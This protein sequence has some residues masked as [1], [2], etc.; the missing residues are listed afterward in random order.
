MC[1]SFKA[2]FQGG[3]AFTSC[4]TVMYYCKTV[5]KKGK[6]GGIKWHGHVR[7]L[8]LSLMHVSS[9]PW[10]IPVLLSCVASRGEKSHFYTRPSSCTV[11]F[12]SYYTK[13]KKADSSCFK[14]VV[15]AVTAKAS[16]WSLWWRKENLFFFGKKNKVAHFFVSLL[17]F[18]FYPEVQKEE[19]QYKRRIKYRMEWKW[20]RLVPE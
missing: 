17:V 13:D 7:S 4:E 11:T 8:Q 1:T 18:L 20:V 3:K 15:A 2:E 5:G 12:S 19:A 16:C 9:L 6:E 14:R 10:K